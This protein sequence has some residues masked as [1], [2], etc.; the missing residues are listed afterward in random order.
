MSKIIKDDLVIID[1]V[2]VF[3]VRHKC[4]KCSTGYLSFNSL[5]IMGADGSF[6]HTCD[7]TDCKMLEH[8]ERKY[9]YIYYK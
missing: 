2:K 4:T 8:L 6:P 3:R 7:N 9:P 1:P 5:H